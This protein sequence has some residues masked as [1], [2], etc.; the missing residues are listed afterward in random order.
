[1][2][3]IFQD[4]MWLKVLDDVTT[5]AWATD[6]N[7]ADGL[8]GTSLTRDV[9]LLCV[10][11]RE[12]QKGGPQRGNLWQVHEDVL[13]CIWRRSDFDPRVVFSFRE[14]RGGQNA[15]IVDSAHCGYKPIRRHEIRPR[16]DNLTLNNNLL[17][18]KNLMKCVEDGNVV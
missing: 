9:L 2:S 16:G 1:M 14:D 10:R 6:L 13:T 12:S 15:C 11:W 17:W 4:N 8:V 7:R 3:F 5:K 18:C